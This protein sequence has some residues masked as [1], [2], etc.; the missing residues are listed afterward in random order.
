[1]L[2]TDI[3]GVSW[4]PIAAWSNDDYLNSDELPGTIPIK[5]NLALKTRKDVYNFFPKG[6]LGKVRAF[7]RYDKAGKVINSALLKYGL[8]LARNI[9]MRKIPKGTKDDIGVAEDVVMLWNGFI[10]AA[11]EDGI[12]LP[13]SE[14]KL[15]KDRET[16]STAIVVTAA[17]L[18]TPDPN[19]MN[20][21]TIVE[22]L[23]TKLSENNGIV[24]D[25]SKGKAQRFGFGLTSRE[26]E[27]NFNGKNA[28]D[29]TAEYSGKMRNS[30]GEGSNRVIYGSV[31]AQLAMFG[32]WGLHDYA[33]SQIWMPTYDFVASIS[34]LSF[35]RKKQK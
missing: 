6:E 14:I 8:N 34:N 22:E 30:S 11:K 10:S 33:I 15:P 28:I 26:V 31:G 1:M 29:R 3:A 21:D 35:E 25:A 12:D 2:K 24:A 9:A 17:A 27:I 16:C 5:V 13:I 4:E 23:T 18:K 32:Q 7:V 20:S 19:Q